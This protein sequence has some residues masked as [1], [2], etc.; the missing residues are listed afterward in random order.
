MK[1]YWGGLCPPPWHPLVSATA[2][3]YSYMISHF[4]YAVPVLSMV[5]NEVINSLYK[6][7]G[8]GILEW[9]DTI[10]NPQSLEEY[11][12]AISNR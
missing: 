11:A 7:H 3:R 10:L 2:C 5:T 4:A 8:H 9:N 12:H 1:N 6:T